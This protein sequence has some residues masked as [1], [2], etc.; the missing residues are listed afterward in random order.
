MSDD[1]D[2]IDGAY[3]VGLD[4][5]L[6]VLVVDG[7]ETLV[8]VRLPAREARRMA[9]LILAACDVAEGDDIDELIERHRS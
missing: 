5:S 8:R 4:G 3:S 6:V 7:A 1:D 2:G 9:T